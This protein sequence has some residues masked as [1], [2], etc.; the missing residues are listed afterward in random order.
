MASNSTVIASL[1]AQPVPEDLCIKTPEELLA[2]V[3]TY[4]RVIGL[5]GVAPGSPLQTNNAAAQALQTAQDALAAVQAIQGEQKALRAS[6]SPASLPAG[7]S[8]LSIN[9]APAMPS[10]NYEVLVTFFSS[11][12][13]GASFNYYIETGS[14]TVN[15]CQLQ[16]RDIPTATTFIWSARQLD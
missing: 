9:W 3:A 14:R 8:G 6:F 12:G 2:A 4:I 15:G 16:F 7:D 10:T 1:E 13:A 11:A 5:A